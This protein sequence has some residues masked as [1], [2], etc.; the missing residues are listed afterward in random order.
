MRV[1]MVNIM[2]PSCGKRKLS[3]RCEECG[4]A[5]I[6]FLSCPRCSQI[7]NAEEGQTCP[8]LQGRRE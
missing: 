5:T 2:C 8:Q 3:S 7:I 4:E 6:R 1:D